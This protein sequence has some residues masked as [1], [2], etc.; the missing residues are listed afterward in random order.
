MVLFDFIKG[1][2]KKNTSPAEP[3]AEPATTAETSAQEIANKL[4]GHIKA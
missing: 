3:Q 2:G 4:L 1:I